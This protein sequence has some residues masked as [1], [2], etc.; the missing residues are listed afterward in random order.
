VGICFLP[1]KQYDHEPTHPYTVRYSMW[2]RPY[3]AIGGNVITLPHPSVKW[4]FYR[5][6]SY[7]CLLRHEK[8]HINGWP[9]THPGMIRVDDYD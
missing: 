4:I 2:P 5:N 1:P 9:E 7:E 3:A 8:A 6:Q